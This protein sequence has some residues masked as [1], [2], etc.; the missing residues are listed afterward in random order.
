MDKVIKEKD[1]AKG[2]YVTEESYVLEGSSGIHY[3]ADGDGVAA[4]EDDDENY[5]FLADG[6]LDEVMDEQDVMNALASYNDTRQALKDQRLGRGFFPGKGKGKINAFQKGKDKGKRRVHIEQ[7][8]LRTRC[9]KCLQVGHWERECQ[10]PPASQAGKGESRTFYVGLRSE[11]DS[12]S[13]SQHDFWLRQFVKESRARQET[14]TEFNNGANP[15]KRYMERACMV[16]EGKVNF[17]GITTQAIE[18]I[19]DTAAEGGLIGKESLHRLKRELA[20]RG[21]RIKWIPKQSFAKGVGGNAVVEGVALI[22]LGLG[23]INGVLETTVVQG[24]VPFLLP[25]KLLRALEAVIDLKNMVMQVPSHQ[26]FLPLRELASG[27]VAVNV[28]SFAEG[29]FLVPP[30]A[31][32]QEMESLCFATTAMP[33][34]SLFAGAQFDRPG[35]AFRPSPPHGVAAEES[36]SIGGRYSFHGPSADGSRAAGIQLSY[37]AQKLANPHGQDRHLAGSRRPPGHHRGLV[38]GLGLAAAGAQ[39]F[40]DNRGLLLGGDHACTSAETPP[41]Q[42]CAYDFHQFLRASQ[43]QSQRGRKWFELVHS[44]PSMPYQVGPFRAGSRGSEEDQ[45]RPLEH[46][47]PEG[48]AHIA[49]EPEYLHSSTKDTDEERGQDHGRCHDGNTSIRGRNPGG[50]DGHEAGLESRDGHSCP[51]HASAAE[52]RAGRILRSAISDERGPAATDSGGGEEG[53]GGEPRAGDPTGEAHADA[54]PG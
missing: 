43:V 53:Y 5:V 35:D 24:D 30:E 41:E 14:S 37:P 25:V 39:V 3:E 33:A 34:Q 19:V 44:V 31:G 2:N 8:K 27:H 4:W 29:K 49:Q 42:E 38:H 16:K 47:V 48:E 23:G 10:N 18:G 15:S 9:R 1:K 51:D 11:S 21:L 22:P 40:G 54:H 7:L 45:G 36:Q 32:T 26:V 46:E 50:P 12:F 6:D 20:G 28:M 17:C 52:E 13:T